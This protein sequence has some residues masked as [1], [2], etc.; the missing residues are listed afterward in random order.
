[1]AELGN[2]ETAMSLLDFGCGCG[3]LLRFLAFYSHR[4][5]LVGVDVEPK[6][7]A[8]CS[9]NLNTALVTRTE[10]VPPLPF[11]ANRFDR[12]VSLSV[13]SHLPED[14]HLKWRDELARVLAPGGRLIM[15]TLGQAAIDAAQ[16][17]RA[18]FDILQISE[19]R[20]ETAI[21]EVARR[22]FSFVLQADHP[23]SDYGIAL[24]SESWVREFWGVHF[25]LEKY[26]PGWAGGWQDGYLLERRK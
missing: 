12:I 18:S 25:T 26:I 17:S 4:V 24:V 16:R 7:I 19:S 21:V 9:C 3:R 20:F 1:V 5:E 22:G 11:L 23:L 6:H 14:A 15:T 10:K 8:W 2:V 13:F